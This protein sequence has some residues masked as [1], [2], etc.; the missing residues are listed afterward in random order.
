MDPSDI[1]NTPF[2]LHEIYK[3]VSVSLVLNV[4]LALIYRV[5]LETNK[6]TQQTTA[7]E[8]GISKGLQ[9]ILLI[10][11]SKIIIHFAFILCGIHPMMLPLHTLISAFYVGMNMMLPVL[12]TSSESNCMQYVDGS[13]A[14][15]VVYR[16]KEVMMYL[17]GPTL[18]IDETKKENKI[19]NKQHQN[20]QRTQY[21]HQYNT[22]GTLIGM[23]AC[24]I[25][26]ILDHGMQIQRYPLPII[27]GATY[28]SCGGILI[29][30]LLTHPFHGLVSTL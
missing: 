28:G 15:K 3:F 16:L 24:T 30:A 9:I 2:P 19:H 25:L 4:L 14:R 26:R 12:L 1:I 5:V 20:A 13:I 23:S 18:I 6:Q 8:G 27:V 22:L 17:F 11:I 29:G 7:T 10:G 21:I